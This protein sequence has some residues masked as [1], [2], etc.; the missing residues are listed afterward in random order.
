MITKIIP[1]EKIIQAHK[2]IDRA[3]RIVIIS[4]IGPDGDAL[5]SAL[6]LYHFCFPWTK[7][8]GLSCQM[9]FLLF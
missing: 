3:E 8:P 9:H 2:A 7:K 5:G 1:E 6:G 4:H